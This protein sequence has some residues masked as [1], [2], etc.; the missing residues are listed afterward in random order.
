MSIKPHNILALMAALGLLAA[1]QGYAQGEPR[2]A[3]EGELSEQDREFVQ[4]VAIA[5]MAE[6][7]LGKLAGQKAT[8]PDVRAFGER[9]VRDHEKAGMKLKSVA[10]ELKL[11]PPK[12]MPEKQKNLGEALAELEGDLFDS[13]YIWNMVAAHTVAVNVFE[14]QI[15]NGANPKLVNSARQTL[16]TLE[17]HR[18]QAVE[19]WE[20]I[21]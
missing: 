21:Q 17:E 15:E 16:P 11:E 3:A 7:K 14:R 20:Q 9:M 18:Q 6:I 5:N 1:S 8:S 4:K 2:P 13:E 10:K 12:R 19:I